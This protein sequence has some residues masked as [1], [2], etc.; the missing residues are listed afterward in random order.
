MGDATG[1]LT[2]GFHLLRLPD[3]GLGGLDLPKTLDHGLGAA[4]Q[5]DFL[6]ELRIGLL[7]LIASRQHQEARQHQQQQRRSDPHRHECHDALDHALDAVGRHPQGQDRQ[8]AG[9]PTGHDVDPEC[10]ERGGELEIAAAPYQQCQ[11]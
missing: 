4:A 6:L 8:Q 11:E 9:H 5:P 1:E 10:Q 3:L 7:E 2:D